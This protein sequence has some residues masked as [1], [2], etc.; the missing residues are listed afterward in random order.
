MTE[1]GPETLRKMADEVRT[2][3]VSWVKIEA[4]AH[5]AAWEADIARREALERACALFIRAAEGRYDA[6]EGGDAGDCYAEAKSVYVTALRGEEPSMSDKT[7]A[8]RDVLVGL[9]EIT[10]AA[11][12]MFSSGPKGFL[13]RCAATWDADI[14]RRVALERLYSQSRLFFVAKRV[15]EGAL[16]LGDLRIAVEEHG[17]LLEEKP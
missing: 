17:A 4:Y 3:G 7:D 14:S 1:L 2:I 6:Q 15:L 9:K 16:D 10:P 5:A 11:L 8:D 12:R 13:A